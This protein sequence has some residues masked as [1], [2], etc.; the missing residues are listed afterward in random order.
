MH[1][2]NLVIDHS[3]QKISKQL[4][5]C[6]Q[7]P[8]V[9]LVQDMT[10]VKKQSLILIFMLYMHCSSQYESKN[11]TINLSRQDKVK[12]GIEKP[13]QNSILRNTPVW[14]WSQTQTSVSH[15]QAIFQS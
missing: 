13:Y 3:R 6:M 11:S 8:V 9:F 7:F 15:K 5:L 10:H 2:Y 4:L 12:M 14:V 1:L